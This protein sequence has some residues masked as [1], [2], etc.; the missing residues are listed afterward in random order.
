MSLCSE[1]NVDEYEYRAMVECYWQGKTEVLGEKNCL[2][3]IFSTTNFTWTL[4]GSNRGFCSQKP[5]TT[6]SKSDWHF[7]LQLV[8]HRKHSATVARAGWLMLCTYVTDIFLRDPHKARNALCGATVGGE[9][10]C[11]PPSNEIKKKTQIFRT[12]LY[13]SFT[14][15]TL[16]PKS[17]TEIGCWPVHWNIEKYSFF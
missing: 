12:L 1:Q 5:A 8:P 17:A 11:N 15:F 3:A 16:L 13:Q 7:R 6:R 10:G 9:L 4:L 14:W 2:S